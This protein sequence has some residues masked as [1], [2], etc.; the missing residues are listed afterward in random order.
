ML[1][2]DDLP[3]VKDLLIDALKSSYQVKGVTTGAEALELLQKERFH[4]L[5]TDIFMPDM[6]GEQLISKVKE[7]GL[8]IVII[9]VTAYGTVENA[10][11][12]MRLGAHD[13]IEKPFELE[14]LKHTVQRAFELLELKKENKVLHTQLEETARLKSLIGN[15]LPLQKIRERIR[16]VASTK[17]TTLIT[18]ESGTGKELVAREIHQMS[19]RKNKPFI[20]VNCAS[21]PESLLE[22]QLFGH[23]KGAFTS[24]YR[25]ATGKFELANTGTILLDEIGEMSATIQ[26]KLLRVIQEGEFDRVGGEDPIKTDARIIATTNRNLREEIQKGRFRED[27]FYRL[28]VVPIEMPPLRERREDIPLLVNHFIDVYAA[29]NSREPVKLTQAAMTKLCSGYWKGNIRELENHI[30]RAV[31]MAG[32]A[33]LDAEFFQ[34]DNEREEQLTKMEHTF[35]YGSIRS[36]EKL[37]ILSRLGDLKENRTKAAKTLDISVRTLRNKLHEYNVRRKPKAAS[38]E[39]MSA[40]PA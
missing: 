22:S 12:L 15:S 33:T 34:L 21:I 38:E 16:L 35:R 14:K 30:E 20:T 29:E 3:E 5:I 25:K 24:A 13:Y 6:S 17:A 19:D 1:V 23:E 26:A 27:L 11:K 32:G 28:N 4:M 7:M 39:E 2:V 31:I 36:M 10:I 9:A 18:G 40:I 8:D 37:M